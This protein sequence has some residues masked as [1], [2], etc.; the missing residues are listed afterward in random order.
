VSPVSER[1]ERRRPGRDD[2]KD[3]APT[4]ARLGAL[5]ST[6]AEA[7]VLRDDVITRCL[8][9]VKAV[10]RFDP[11][12][13]YDFV[14]YAVP[15]IMGEVRRYFRDVGWSMRVPRRMQEMHALITKAVDELSQ[16]L[17]RSP[18]ASEIAAELDLD[19]REV[20]EGLLAK[21]AYQTLSMDATMGDDPDD[22]PLAETLGE[23]DPELANVE[24][25]AAVRPALEKL[26]PLERRVLMLRFF[27]SM[28]QTEIAQRVGVSQ[29]Q[30]SRILARTLAGLREQLGDG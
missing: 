6:S 10:D 1:S 29:M 15:T 30:V 9:L 20:S 23:E 7:S 24:S 19:V 28:T 3:V 14:S 4:L 2:Y 16:D 26:P 25:H 17:G 13:G 27:G 21:N 12:R 5:E 18:S 22:L 8:G 11:D